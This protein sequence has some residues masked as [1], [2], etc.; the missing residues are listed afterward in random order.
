MVTAFC[1][2]WCEIQVNKL[3]LSLKNHSIMCWAHY[4]INFWCDEPLCDKSAVWQMHWAHAISLIYKI[5]T[6]C[7][8]ISILPCIRKSFWD[9]S[10]RR[11]FSGNF[12]GF[13]EGKIGCVSQPQTETFWCFHGVATMEH[14]LVKVP[15]ENHILVLLIIL[16]KKV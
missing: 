4:V 12:E 11:T 13:R 6:F 3:N 14:V 15:P 16:C 10:L 8:K 7:E 9:N 2:V 5:K 1:S